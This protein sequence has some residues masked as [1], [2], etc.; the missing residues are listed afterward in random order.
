MKKLFSVLVALLTIATTTFALEIDKD[1]FYVMSNRNDNN[2]YIKDRG[3]D[4]LRM[5]AG[6]DNTSYWRFIPSGNP[7]CYF[8]QNLKTGRYAQACDTKTEVPIYMGTEPVEYKVLLC[9]V[10]GTDCY[11][12]A[13][14]N[15]SNTNFTSGC[16][17]WNWRNDDV[18][19]TFAAVAGTNHRSFWKLS[20]AEPPACL[21]GNH[22][23]ENGVCIVC[24]ETQENYV[25]LNE[26]G[27]YELK[28]AADVEWF[29]DL[30]N[31]GDLT[32]CAVLM[33]D[34]DMTGVDHKL[35]GH[36]TGQKF[37]GTFDGQGHRIKNLIINRPNDSN[38]GFFGFLRGNN[39][40]TVV[41]NL[42]IDKSCSF[43]GRNRVG[44]IAGSAQNGG[45]SITIE[46][47]I[48]EADIF[49]TGQDAGG[50]VGGLEGGNP[51]WT[52]RNCVNTGNI[53]SSHDNAYLGAF[54]CYTEHNVGSV[55]E[56]LINLGT[57]GMHNGGNMG[58]MNGVVKNV[59][60]LSDTEDISQGDPSEFDLTQE[61]VA[62]GKLAFFMNGNQKQISFYQTLGE[63]AYPVPFSTSKQ[64]Y[65]DGQMT[66]S[67]EPVGDGNYTNDSS[68]SH[69]PVHT[70]VD[71]DFYC[72]ECGSVNENFCH[73]TDGVYHLET[74]K[75]LCWFAAYVNA[76]YTD[77]DA[78]LTAD[79]D[80]E[81]EYFEGIGTFEAGYKGHFNGQFHTISNLD[82]SD[83]NHD[84]CGFFNFLNGGAVIENLRLDKTCVISGGKGTAL[85]GGSTKEG[86]VL[87]RNLANEGDVQSYSTC[88][89]GILGANYSSI[90]KVTVE[91]C[92]STGNIH[93]GSESAAL[94]GWLGSNGGVVRNCWT[95]AT[96]AGI[97]NDGRYAVR[98]ENG[99]L[100]N[101]YSYNGTQG[102]RFEWEDMESGALAY[103]L[104]E[105]LAEPVW[106]QNLDN[107]QE[108]DVYP[109]ADATHGVVYPVANRLCDGS[110]NAEDA[111]YSNSNVS[112]IPDHKFHEGFCSVCG[113]EDEEYPF[114][115][116][117]ANADHDVTTGYTNEDS[118]DGSRLAINNS[119]AEHWNQQWFN[120]YQ[121]VT[122]LEKGIYRLRLQGLQRV[123]QWDN[124]GIEYGSGELDPKFIPLY[125]SSQYYAQVGDKM[126]S[127]LFMDITACK[128]AKSFE[129]TENY[130]DNTEC[131]VPNS[132]SAARK[133]FAKGNYWNQPIYFA[134]NGEE[135][136]V[137]FGVQNHVYK[138]GNWTVWDTWRLE[139]M[140]MDDEEAMELIRAQQTE[141]VQVLEEL[142]AQTTLLDA[143]NQ[144][145]EDIES[146]STL[147]EILDA[148]DI[149]S[150]YP[151]MIRQ[152]YFAYQNF[153]EAMEKLQ[154]QV[155]MQENLNGEYA[156]L[157]YSFLND[158][159]EPSEELPYG[160]FMYIM[161][162]RLLSVEELNALVPAMEELLALAIK[163]SIAEGSDLTYLVNN[164]GFDQD[165]NFKGWHTEV[166]RRGEGGDNLNSN[167]GFTDIYPVAGSWN[168]AFSV[169]Q[170]LEEGL[171]NG[172]YEIEAPA[173]NRTG[174]NGQGNFDGSDLV[175]SDI[176]IN[177]YYTPVMN[178]YKGQ[179][180]YDDAVNGVNCRYDSEND[181]EA[182]H[183]GE[184]PSSRDTDTGEGWVPEQRYAMSFAFN[185]GRYV[186]HAYAIVTDGKL[187]I[188]IRNTGEPWYEKGVTCWGKFQLRYHGKS[189]DA[190]DAMMKN[191]REHLAN[192]RNAVTEQDYYL[193][194][195]RLDQI[196]ALM[197]E[198]EAA[199][200]A[201][202]KMAKIADLNEAFNQIPE[203]HNAYQKLVELMDY[204][205]E[206]AAEASDA[207]E[208]DKSDALYEACDDMQLVLLDCKLSED[209]IE[210]YY[211]SVLDKEEIGGGLFVQGDIVDA[212][213]NKL[214]YSNK[215]TAYL[216]TPKGS[217]KYTGT[218]RTQNRANLA[219][220]EA[221]AGIYFTHFC[222]TY[223]AKDANH[224]FVT[225]ALADFEVVTE[226]GSDFQMV[227]GEFTVNLD[228]KAKTI[229]F[230]AKEYNW[231]DKVYV[232]G[233][234]LDSNLESHRWKND[235]AAPL[236]H[237][238]NGVYEGDILFEEDY[239]NP[240]FATFTIM[241]CR[242]TEE[243]VLFSTK[244]R[245]SWYE[246]RYG[247][248]EGET[249]LESGVTLTDLVRGKDS[250]WLISWTP[251]QSVAIYTVTF[252][253][254][255]ATITIVPGNEDGI[256]AA[257]SLVEGKLGAIYNLA[258]QKVQKMQKGIYIQA[259]QKLLK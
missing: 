196:E 258:G 70:F 56:N 121:T 90:A 105:V 185:A 251:G 135:D 165:G 187:R 91:N 41:R 255:N 44:G 129:D 19:Q 53:S 76:G 54:F 168:T 39:A 130:N 96:A 48:N 245:L 102:K 22:Q 83:R 26:Q 86:S 71:G 111:T 167:T 141:N 134:V 10:E 52:V 157:L 9:S 104:N 222:N 197:G 176:F 14:T 89:G 34:I 23:Y 156:D 164:P 93:G 195:A 220:A 236:T 24:G 202:A 199:S 152:S 123:C 12:L 114:L 203:S 43:T 103:K 257:T 240:G 15:L 256:D 249:H 161:D 192:L 98:H 92:Y 133:Y 198:V 25:H 106:F 149:L 239:N 116:V 31:G 248:A 205:Y 77:V 216:L 144:A 170:D 65:F 20:E 159:D 145:T 87:L 51:V 212:E 186:N 225:P 188:G 61:D 21:L 17:G 33:N 113:Q 229:E 75:E 181:P 58:R 155:D 85:V 107:D 142:E 112:V 206:K 88:A 101:I 183:N 16:I 4:L 69:I 193:Y 189:M 140:D 182:P 27:F 160:T 35:I 190:I 214:V 99:T 30:V 13:S 209:A 143:Y 154:E 42:I 217:G 6:V 204:C 115:N 230:V 226:G 228:L 37:N 247:S 171:P 208:F 218:F 64:V 119:V 246:G 46:N 177:D 94:V 29:A 55:F 79:I 11:G 128:S 78:V 36:S 108:Q 127:N 207:E 122:G 210:D 67:G 28:N 1:K 201:E 74:A 66:C 169:W 72:Q 146:A 174:D 139:K 97:D 60:D 224:R 253:M 223:R 126:V 3:E 242:S 150:R 49:V 68:V 243:D 241:A 32:A 227:G 200:G 81:D 233:S 158:Y 173:F 178:I 84:W 219:N 132:L 191:Y 118:G 73:P 137:K 82:M 136:V 151:N 166:Y 184:F 80:L 211:Y 234:I 179:V 231:N 110:F 237:K 172:I 8:I 131:Y 138:Y 125:H 62:S 175:N 194:N 7:N 153:R 50:L 45:A 38:I 162:E 215:N 63:D 40:P 147:E 2:R 47:C 221:R 232:C 259:G 120:S 124:S 18:V 244:S 213:G 163:N 117:F 180:L 250:K 254:N 148:A 238:G 109:T 252:D 5:G 235:E 95:V 57:I 100:T 59:I